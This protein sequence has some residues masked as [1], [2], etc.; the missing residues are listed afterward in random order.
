MLEVS[1]TVLL[2][3]S[4]RSFSIAA[5]TGIALSLVWW[6]RSVSSPW[7]M[8]QINGFEVHLFEIVF[9]AFKSVGNLTIINLFRTFSIPWK[10]WLIG[11]SVI[12]GL[13]C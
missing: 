11:L 6:K 9:W 12:G 13:D 8:A 2:A 5:T 10:G 7:T 1:C 3:A 4:S